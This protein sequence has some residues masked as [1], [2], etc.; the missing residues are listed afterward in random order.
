[1][2]KY[3]IGI[4]IVGALSLVM[5]LFVWS[6]K[7]DE[8]K[9][10]LDKAEQRNTELAAQNNQLQLSLADERAA[11]DKQAAATAEIQA[12]AEVKNKEV[13]YVLK[14]STCANTA[15]P[16]GAIKLLRK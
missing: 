4:L 1:M 16:S 5:L 3:I 14:S 6:N 13:I 8:L 7:I 15:I 2:T 9:T 12:E 10:E 11:V